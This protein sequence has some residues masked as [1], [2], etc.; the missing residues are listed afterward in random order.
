MVRPG[1]ASPLGGVV[2]YGGR[3]SGRVGS[4][5]VAGDLSDEGMADEDVVDQFMAAR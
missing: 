3:R 1:R 4:D 5:V 2:V